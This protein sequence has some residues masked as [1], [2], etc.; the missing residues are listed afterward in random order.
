MG[1]K[2]EKIHRETYHDIIRFYDLA[3]EI[4]DSVD[5]SQGDAE[6]RLKAVEPLVY[7]V[8]QAT[9]TLALEYR[10]YVESGKEPGLITRKRIERALDDIYK[11]IE[12]FKKQFND[13]NRV[14]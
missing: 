6:K 5:E 1:V 8:E 9:D 3:E 7:K 11:C 12:T 4:I 14:N 2:I 13:N 10:N